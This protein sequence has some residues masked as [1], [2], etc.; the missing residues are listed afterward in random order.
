MLEYR[1]MLV[2]IVDYDCGNLYSVSNV[3]ETLGVNW[4]H[5]DDPNLLSKCTHIILPGVGSFRHAMSKLEERQLRNIII[6]EARIGKKILGICV[7]MQILFQ[8]GKEGG[9]QAGLGLLKGR[10]DKINVPMLPSVGW[11]DV[12]DTEG[13]ACGSFYFTHSYAASNVRDEFL[14]Y[15]AQGNKI[16]AAVRNQNIYGTQFHPEKSG[17]IGQMLLRKFCDE[18]TNNRIW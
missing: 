3:L 5:T 6:K 15:Y 10:V 2:G 17:P 14:T 18:N 16:I 8:E 13:V 12:S 1:E 9:I 11:Y 4:T 7:G